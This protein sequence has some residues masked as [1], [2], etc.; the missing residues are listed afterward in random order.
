[1]M[2]DGEWAISELRIHC[3]RATCAG[4]PKLTIRIVLANAFFF[5]LK[6]IAVTRSCSS[7]RQFPPRSPPGYQRNCC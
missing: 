4:R 5:Y 7:G 2:L 6:C 1:V 3:V